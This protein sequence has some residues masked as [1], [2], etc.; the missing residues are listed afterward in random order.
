MARYEVLGTCLN[1]GEFVESPTPSRQFSGAANYNFNLP[2]TAGSA[3]ELLTS[4]G[5]GSNPDIAWPGYAVERQFPEFGY[6]HGYALSNITVDSK[7]GCG[8]SIWSGW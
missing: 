1:M 5:G 6:D 2:A 7:E 3:G 8:P 4:G